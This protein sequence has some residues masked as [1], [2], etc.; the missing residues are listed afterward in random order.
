[1]PKQT[2]FI[3]THKDYSY[4]PA[5][6]EFLMKKMPL[7]LAGSGKPFEEENSRKDCRYDHY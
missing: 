4:V 7:T 5:L 2:P 6:L 1:M 3:I